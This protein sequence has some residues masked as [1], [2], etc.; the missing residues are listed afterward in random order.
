[1][2]GAKCL[3]LPLPFSMM[4]PV[5]AARTDLHQRPDIKVPILFVATIDTN[6]VGDGFIFAVPRPRNR[7][8]TEAMTIYNN[9]GVR[10]SR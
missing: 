8:L 10:M 2:S 6:V 5:G 9:G 1:M 7:G 4:F 3:Y